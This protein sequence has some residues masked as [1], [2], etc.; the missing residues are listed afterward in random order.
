MSDISL[1]YYI[2]STSLVKILFIQMSYSK[3]I[4]QYQFMQDELEINMT[5]SSEN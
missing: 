4:T 5:Q 1:S 2:F 3:D